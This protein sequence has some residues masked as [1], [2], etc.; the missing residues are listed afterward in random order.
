MGDAVTAFLQGNVEFWHWWI[1]GVLLLLLEVLAP[2]TFF[3][4][5]GLAA[6]VVGLLLVILPDLGWQ[7]QVLIF[8]VLSVVAVFA[9]RAWLKRHPIKTEDTG[10]NR[11]A[12]ALVGQI[13]TLAEAIH[14]GRGAVKVGD[15]VWR[16]EG[17]DLPKGARVRVI[18][19]EGTTLKVEAA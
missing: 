3:L 13:Y 7:L 17:P 10:L 6:G 8:A 19:V 18:A 11:R 1:L 2:G 5:L 9:G 12:D 4:W 15:T 14:V 16:A